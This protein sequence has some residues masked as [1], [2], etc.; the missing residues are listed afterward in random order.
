MAKK[1][2][3]PPPKKTGGFQSGDGY[4]VQIGQI[5][6]NWQVCLGTRGKPGTDHSANSYAIF[7]LYCRHIYGANSG[8]VWQRL[9]PKCQKGKGEDLKF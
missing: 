2:I 1:E 3:P 5:N 9:C 4:S 7:C 8:D 6:R